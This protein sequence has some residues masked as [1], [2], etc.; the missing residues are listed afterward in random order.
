MDV[1]GLSMSHT[2][3]LSLTNYPGATRNQHVT[4]QGL[5]VFSKIEALARPSRLPVVPLFRTIRCNGPQYGK[6]VKDGSW[7]EDLLALD[8]WLSS[9]L[10]RP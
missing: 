9:Y 5:P 8:R 7:A 3:A 4:G 1:P 10:G 6:S 2:A